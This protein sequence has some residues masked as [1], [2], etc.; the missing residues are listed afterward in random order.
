MHRSQYNRSV[1]VRGLAIA[2]VRIAV[3]AAVLGSCVFETRTTF[4]ERF[5]VRCKE[6]QQCATDQA[7]CID[8]GGCG[9]HIVDTAKGEA[10]DDVGGPVHVQKDPADANGNGEADAD[11]SDHRR[12]ALAASPA[13]QERR[14]R[15][16][17]GC[18]RGVAARKRRP[19]RL[20]DGVE[21]GR[22]RRPRGDR[23]EFVR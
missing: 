7:V 1:R 16:K 17:G 21:R 6:G 8:I 19:Q 10:C 18:E 11:S 23:R 14:S 9:D 5:G 12:R 3:G 15:K 20:G 2:A 13:Q 22:L 4:C